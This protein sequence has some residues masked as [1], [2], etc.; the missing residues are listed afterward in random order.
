MS[1]VWRYNPLWLSKRQEGDIYDS[2]GR[3]HQS[4]CR[5]KTTLAIN[6]A[7]ARANAGKDVLLVDGDEQHTAVTL[8]KS[9]S[10]NNAAEKFIAGADASQEEVS[11]VDDGFAQKPPVW[12]DFV[13]T[14][15]FCTKR[16]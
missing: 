9:L 14:R 11:Q 2:H 16:L 13:C 8:T 3:E 7:I 5:H 15:R 6:L 10:Q 12:R 4:R 1:F